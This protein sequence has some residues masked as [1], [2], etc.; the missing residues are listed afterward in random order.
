MKVIRVDNYDGKGPGSDEKVVAGP[1]LTGQEADEIC[2]QRQEDP[3]RPD[4][5]WFRAVE[6]DHVL[7]RFEL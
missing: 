7:R 2:R 6:D 4:R 3:K 5:Y 1:G